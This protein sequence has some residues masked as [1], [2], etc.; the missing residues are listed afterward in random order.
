[1]IDVKSLEEERLQMFP[2]GFCFSLWQDWQGHI[3]S[4]PS[5]QMPL[6]P[7]LTGQIPTQMTLRP[8]WTH[9]DPHSSTLGQGSRG[10]LQKWDFGHCIDCKVPLKIQNKLRKRNEKEKRIL[11]SLYHPLSAIVSYFFG[12]RQVV[13]GRYTEG[14]GF[15]YSWE[16][17]LKIF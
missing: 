12:G 4:S 17:F 13:L 11:C 9:M 3:N 10:K 15:F 16:I 14:E 7:Y 2:Q 8:T 1:M 6:F 5:V